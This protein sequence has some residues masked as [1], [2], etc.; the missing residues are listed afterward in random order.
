M[1]ETP[2]N[3]I[4]ISR[5]GYREEL[6]LVTAIKE[7][8]QNL[9]PSIRTADL[10]I[11]DAELYVIVSI[12]S[13]I[14]ANVVYALLKHS[15]RQLIDHWKESRKPVIYVCT[16]LLP[17]RVYKLPDEAQEAL[18]YLRRYKLVKDSDA[19]KDEK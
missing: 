5:H 15:A 1:E 4:E 18:D 10:R 11:L 19:T 12:G 6:I 8:V 2:D 14:A 9:D 3:V 13:G 7:C 16:S 17:K